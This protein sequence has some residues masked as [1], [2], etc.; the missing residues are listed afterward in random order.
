MRTSRSFS[1]PTVVGSPLDGSEAENSIM[2]SSRSNAGDR[3]GVLAGL[4]P[5]Q[6]EMISMSSK[7]VSSTYPLQDAQ[8]A[9]ECHQQCD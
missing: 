9:M 4:K 2:A 6:H 3:C 7:E 5:M 1:D 8:P